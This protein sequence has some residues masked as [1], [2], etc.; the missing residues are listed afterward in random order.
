MPLLPDSKVKDRYGVCLKTLR[1]WDDK[2]E[3]KFP[4]PKVINNRKYRD[5]AELDN[6]DAARALAY[7]KS[8]PRGAAAKSSKGDMGPSGMGTRNV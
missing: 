1:R 4:L 5:V 3:M 8:S 2:P 7:P 6:W